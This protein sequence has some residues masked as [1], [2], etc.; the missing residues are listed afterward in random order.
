MGKNSARNL[1][2]VLTLLWT[3][4]ILYGE[5]FAFWL[6]SLWTCSWPH[7]TRQSP[8]SS[9]SS[10]NAA[11]YTDDYVKV[12]VIA[13]PQLM[14]RTSLHLPPK[15]LALEIAQFYTDLY[16]RRAVLS[17]V[18]P[19]K[20]DVILFMGDYFDG[21]S[22]LSDEEWQ[23]S[24]DRF[25][26]V[27][28][29]STLQSR[30]IP[31]YY[32]PGNHD[33]GYAAQHPFLP[34]VIK[35]YEENFHS[36]NYHFKVGNVD[37][38]AIDAQTVDGN[39]QSNLTSETWNFIKDFSKDVNLTSR[40][41][42]SHIPLYRPDQT[43]CGPYRSSPV[44]NQR[45]HRG[46]QNNGVLYQNYV[47]EEASK[48]LL[49]LIRPAVILSG[50][51]HD[52]CTVTH[53]A[54]EGVVIE[55]TIGTVSWQQGNLHPSFML[56]SVSNNTSTTTSEKD[57]MILMDLCFLPQQLYIYLWYIILFVLTILV[58]VLW[59]RNG[60]ECFHWFGISFLFGI[61]SG[62]AVKEKNEDDEKCEYEMVWDAEG[63]MHLIKKATK[64]TSQVSSS[65]K[66]ALERGKAVMRPTAKKQMVE[67]VDASIIDMNSYTQDTTR[68]H[69]GSKAKGN[70]WTRKIIGRMLRAVR[71]FVV[72]A[73]VNLPLYM[74]LLFKDWIDK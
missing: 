71:M 60:I 28:D 4:T 34:Q 61:G 25:K 10:S 5:M 21:G 8:S 47:T 1:T 44:I 36:R 74:M 46:G 32:I 12:A 42:L 27:F 14:D 45:I 13:D 58:L 65:D 33:I 35:R 30:G 49:D 69:H 53:K 2:L 24:L 16:M 22:I 57:M 50:H 38:I 15:S 66:S 29:L 67:E 7:L 9:S 52:Q 63:N 59:P 6:P 39:V 3:A 37:F 17:S 26:H 51:D 11:E 56:L 62:G 40:V 73:A 64:P 70:A 55:H 41:L 18:L 54:K 31:I 20:P 72:I 48:N 23:E 43:S 19:F 68:V